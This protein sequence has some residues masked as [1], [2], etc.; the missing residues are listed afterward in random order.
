MIDF[1]RLIRVHDGHEG[2]LVKP[3]RTATW[4]GTISDFWEANPSWSLADMRALLAALDRDDHV[5]IGGHTPFGRGM[6]VYV[7]RPDA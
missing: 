4:R 5:N 3:K 1:D 7:V 6:Q 2:G